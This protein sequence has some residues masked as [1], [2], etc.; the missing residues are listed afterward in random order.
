MKLVSWNVNGYRAI[1][2]KNFLEW[3]NEI[4]AD[5][6]GLQEVKAH[7][8][9]V[10]PAQME[11]EGYHCYWHAARKP[12]YSGTAVWTKKKPLS[13]SEGFGVDSIQAEGRAQILEFEDFFFINAYFPN[14]QEERV[15]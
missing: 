9:A 8:E 2:G 10:N 11:Q 1:L 12:G 5:I 15:M 14:S 7:K 6:V 13:Y 3:F 4:D